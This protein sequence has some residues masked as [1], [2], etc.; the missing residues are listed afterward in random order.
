MTV[1]PGTHAEPS[2]RM[3][4]DRMSG[5][6]AGSSGAPGPS[7]SS[8]A[9]GTP[10]PAEPFWSL[11]PSRASD[12]LTCPL[13]Y[14]FRV[15]DR[16]PEKPSPEAARGT[17]VH[18]VLERLFDLPPG[19]RTLEEADMLL[20]PQWETLL[21]AEPELADLIGEDEL[22]GFFAGARELLTTYFTLEDPNRLQPA[23]RETYIECD[24]D[25][26]LRLRGYIDRLDVAPNGAIRVVDYK[27]GKAP[28]EA[29]EQRALFQMR[30][31]ALVLWRL[32][33]VIPAVLRLVYLGSGHVLEYTPDEADLRATE[34]KLGA[35]WAAIKRA[36]ATGEWRANPGPLCDWCDHR[37][38]CP[39]W[40][41]TPPP[42]PVPDAAASPD[43]DR[44]AVPGDDAPSGHAS[45]VDL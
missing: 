45:V 42:L 20:R 16:I 37:V 32:R 23:E 36:Y 39:A 29:Y 7:V 26:G 38:R 28:R 31:Y 17:V 25:S 6:A 22:E 13:L 5:D 3:S 9:S 34:R 44:P 30:F 8:D 12:F 11:S 4:R 21:A 19:R 1:Q 10:G 14:R 27:T 18:A 33:N 15:I 40:G 2:D 24:L 43:G 35:I 41:G